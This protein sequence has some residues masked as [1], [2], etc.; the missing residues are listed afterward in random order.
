MRKFLSVIG[1][2][3]LTAV[4]IV[5]GIVSVAIIKDTSTN[6]I[7]IDNL[8]PIIGTIGGFGGGIATGILT[9]ANFFSAKTYDK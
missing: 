8:L 1:L 7:N 4:L 2:G 5:I 9:V 3:F 6:S